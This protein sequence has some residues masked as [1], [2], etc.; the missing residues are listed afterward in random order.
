VCGL[1]GA[2]G[3]GDCDVSRSLSVSVYLLPSSIKA[4]IMDGE[5]GG[6]GAKAPRQGERQE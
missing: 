2:R 1:C 3:D 4:L 6:H 5:K